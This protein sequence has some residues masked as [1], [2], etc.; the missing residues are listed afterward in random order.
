MALSLRSWT[1]LTA[2]HLLLGASIIA[3]PEGRADA[4]EVDPVESTES[5]TTPSITISPEVQSI[6]DAGK[7]NNQVQNHLDYLTN[8][9]GP[10]LTGSRGLQEACEWAKSHFESMGLQNAQIEKWGEFPVGFDRGPAYGDMLTPKPM[11]LNFGT[12]A[13]TAGTK[14]RVVGKAMMA[15]KSQEELETIRANLSGTYVLLPRAPRGRR[16]PRPDR[17]GESGGE[18]NR[19]TEN[20]PAESNATDSPALSAEEIGK[21]RTEL[22]KCNVAGIVQ[23]TNDELILTGGNF[24]VD[25]NNLPTTPNISLQKSQWDEIAEL[26]KNGEEV[27]L[28]FDIRNHFKKGP[29]SLYNVF[30]DIPGT[31]LPNEMVIV[32]GH[33]D[34]WDGATGATDNAAGCATTFEAARILMAAGARPKRTIRFMLWSGEEQGLLG[35]KGYVEQNPDLMERISAVLVHDGGTN[36]VAGIGGTEA[37]KPL[38]EQAFGP[39]LQLDPR[40]PF[41]IR[42]VDEILPRGGSDHVSFIEAGVPGFFWDQRGRATYRTTHHTQF[43]TYDTIVPEY[44]QHSSIVIAVGAFGIANLDQMLPRD[45]VKRGR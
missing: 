17:N 29:I 22:L 40:A 19:P 13:W 32:G 11:V 26:L 14:G 38:F 16:G 41:E 36:Y 39:V 4:Q 37:M 31:E 34:S 6:I 7:T 2:L 9:I 25:W 24:Q 12:N 23:S 44:Q 35:S 30:A 45:Q 28:S 27:T 8:Q 42:T 43:D 1:K 5:A 18:Q 33:I 20:R 10:R 15:P 21:I 3:L